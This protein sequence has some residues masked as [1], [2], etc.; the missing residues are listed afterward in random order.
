ML[1]H[2]ITAIVTP[3]RADGTV[4]LERFRELATFVVDN[5]SDGLVVCGTTGESPTLT[6]EEKLDLFRAAVDS[7]G[8]RATVIAGAGT[9]DTRHSVHLTQAATEIGVDGILVVTPYYNKPPQRAIVRHFE[10]IA[11]A[12]GLP[13]M[14]Y[15]IPSR[16]VVNIEPATI[17]RLA[18]IE[19][20]VAVKQAHDD[21]DEARFIAEE[22]R[23]DLYS[24]DDP[25]T[26]DFLELGGV[27]VV[28]VTAHLWGRQIA[29][30][31]RLHGQGDVA[32]ARAIHEELEPSYDLLK[33]QTN[34]IAIK[35]ALNLTGHEVGGHR[36]PMVEAD[37]DELS[38]VRA[39]L[40]RAGLL[41]AATS[42]V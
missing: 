30:L 31:I 32:G 29:E 41:A 11:G 37:E 38:H 16:V 22:T 28:S 19:N 13:V 39:C 18:E 10:E 17:A 23:L 3:F 6:D 2:V 40:E 35:A 14:A 15:N 8:D 24:G 1:G 36:L 21:L 12:T 27:G 7:V 34:P 20:V 42:G 33:I 26:F 9:Y 5:G 25:V 4:D